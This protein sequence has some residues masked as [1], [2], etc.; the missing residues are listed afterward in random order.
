MQIVLRS[1][2]EGLIA[3]SAQRGRGDEHAKRDVKRE[4]VQVYQEHVWCR[5]RFYMNA[6]RCIG[7]DY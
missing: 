6:A 4:V 7:G 1:P 2:N 5:M 3:E